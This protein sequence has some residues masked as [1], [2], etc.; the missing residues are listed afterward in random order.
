MSIMKRSGKQ[1][2][3]QWQSAIVLVK[4]VKCGYVITRTIFCEFFFSSFIK[5]KNS[6]LQIT[7]LFTE[8]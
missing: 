1:E 3:E 2:E 6:F 8:N 7:K 5:L 4:G